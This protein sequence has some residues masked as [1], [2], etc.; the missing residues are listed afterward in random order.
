MLVVSNTSPILNLAIVNL[1]DLLKEQFDRVLIPPAVRAELKLE[2]DL[3]GVE[4]ARAALDAGWITVSN[5]DNANLVRVL[6]L[7][8]D[9]GEAEAIALA[10]QMGAQRILMDEREGRVKAKAM[11]LT[12]TGVLGILLRAKR[13]GK[14]Q[15]VESVMNALK[16]E[17]GFYIEDH[18]RDEILKEAGET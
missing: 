14:L 11:G 6:S 8:L 7:E 16:Q 13:D 12:P 10:L 1:L 4:R 17:A 3:P 2:D 5:V 9:D 15:S 18:L